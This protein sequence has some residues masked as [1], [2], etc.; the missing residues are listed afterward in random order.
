MKHMTLAHHAL[1]VAS[2]TMMT[3]NS[4]T[5]DPTTTIAAADLMEPAD[6]LPHHTM[7]KPHLRLP[8][9][10]RPLRLQFLRAR[11]TALAPTPQ[12][13]IRHMADK[14]PLTAALDIHPPTHLQRTPALHL[15]WFSAHRMAAMATEATDIVVSLCHTPPLDIATCNL[16]T[17]NRR[18]G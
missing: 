10:H 13:H 11:A 4:I 7:D 18:R 17:E 9:L 15:L 16:V 5:E 12:I 6:Y 1:G 3:M 8:L 2:G 14:P